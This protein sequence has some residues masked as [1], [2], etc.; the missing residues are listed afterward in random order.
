MN[1]LN[2]LKNGSGLR[3]DRIDKP[4]KELDN[5]FGEDGREYLRQWKSGH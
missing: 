3:F 5:D 4:L 1:G 2:M